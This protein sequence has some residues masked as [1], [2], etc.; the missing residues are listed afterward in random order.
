MNSLTII[1]GIIDE[2]IQGP[3]YPEFAVN[4]TYGIVAYNETVYNY[5]QFALNFPGGCLAYI[6][7]CA[8]SDQSTLIGQAICNEAGNMCRDNVEA[9]YY[10][11]G[12]RGV[13]DIR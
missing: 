9:P 12:D 8:E 6:E 13:Y 3:Y 7:Y 1:N 11:F 10:Y 5:A 4:N 2:G